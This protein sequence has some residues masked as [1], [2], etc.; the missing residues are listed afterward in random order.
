MLN[1]IFHAML[2]VISCQ[3]GSVFP[4]GRRSSR[5]TSGMTRSRVRPS[6]TYI[7][8]QISYSGSLCARLLVT[9]MKNRAYPAR[10]FARQLKMRTSFQAVTSPIRCSRPMWDASN[11][12]GT[13]SVGP[14]PIRSRQSLWSRVDQSPDATL[15]KLVNLCIWLILCIFKAN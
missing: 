11:S 4:T 8:P 7:R 6:F 9:G 10:N 5:L 2:S 12:P 3:L 13:G 14:A 15:L 1:R